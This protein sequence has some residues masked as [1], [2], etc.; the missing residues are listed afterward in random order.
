[1][2]AISFLHCLKELGEADSWPKNNFTG[3]QTRK[4]KEAQKGKARTKSFHGSFELKTL[5]LI[6]I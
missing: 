1:M 3:K 6:R 5:T 4:L 2:T